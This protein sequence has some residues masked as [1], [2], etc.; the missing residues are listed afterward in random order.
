[1]NFKVIIPI[2]FLCT[3]SIAP[4]RAQKIKNIQN[5]G[6]QISN[7]VGGNQAGGLSNDKIVGGLKDALDV[8]TKNTVNRVSASDGFLKNPSIK[9][10]FP[11]SAKKM[12]STL[13][14][15]GMG[16]QVDK[17]VTSL[18]RAAEDASKE[19]APIFTN[20][21]RGMSISDGMSILKGQDN[22]ATEFLKTNTNEQLKAKMRP[23]VKQAISKNQVAQYWS[24]LAKT[25]N[26]LPTTKKKV[27]PNL[28]EY[29]TDRALEGLFRG[30]ADE[31]LKIRKDP[32][33]R[34]TDLLKQV[35]GSL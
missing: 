22:A 16:P 7:A 26:Q 23:I 3:I 30:I 18:N 31:E 21:I 33:S 35:F 8:G 15:M 9:I 27:Q 14:N 32:A 28:E 13:K 5:V 20:A 6:N 34:V 25:Y 29:V 10:P 2:L 24:P 19:A 4:A 17:F 11:P 12:E 1:M